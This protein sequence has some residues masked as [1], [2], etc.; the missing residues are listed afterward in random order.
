M[1]FIKGKENKI[2]TDLQKMIGI[3]LARLNIETDNRP[4]QAHLTLGRAKGTVNLK[5]KEIKP[6]NFEV[7]SI[8]LMESHLSSAGASY[9]IV[10]SY[11]LNE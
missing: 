5:I 9:E 3:E 4:W 6:F 1:I 7:A 2:L 8:E 11:L 10:E